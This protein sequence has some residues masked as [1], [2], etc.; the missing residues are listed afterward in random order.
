[1]IPLRLSDSAPPFS[2]GP[3]PASGAHFFTLHA[4]R[5]GAP[6]NSIHF[7]SEFHAAVHL[8]AIEGWWRV[9]CALLLPRTARLVATLEARTGPAEAAEELKRRLAPCLLRARQAWAPH[10]ECRFLAGPTEI[11][12]TLR[13]LYLEPGRAGLC[14]EG[15]AWPG[16]L[17]ADE[18][19]AWL[20][21]TLTNPAVEAPP[22]ERTRPGS[23]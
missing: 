5:R 17:G 16:Y 8:L 1:M 18:D 6:L 22:P 9:R 12:D 10:H 21:S 2:S 11:A 15:E 4:G 13:T 20:E 7:A 19:R 14:A 23:G 3:R